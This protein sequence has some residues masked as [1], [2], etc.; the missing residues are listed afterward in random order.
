MRSGTLLTP[1]LA[2]AIIASCLFVAVALLLSPSAAAAAADATT[3]GPQ[4]GNGYAGTLAGS[5]TVGIVISGLFSGRGQDSVGAAIPNAHIR[6]AAP[7]AVGS[8]FALD[9][10]V[11]VATQHF[12]GVAG[13]GSGAAAAVNGTIRTYFHRVHKNILVR[14]VSVVRG[15]ADAA[16]PVTVPL[17]RVVD[18]NPNPALVEQL[19]PCSAAGCVYRTLL[20][21]T[22]ASGLIVVATAEP[23]EP[24]SIQLAAGATNATRVFPLAVVTSMPGDQH[25]APAS[26]AAAQAAAAAA[27]ANFAAES[28][29]QRYAEHAQAWAELWR[30]R[31][32][33]V[34]AAA[35][36]GSSDAALGA[37]IALVVRESQYQLLIALREGWHASTNPGGVVGCYGSS[38]FWDQET[39]MGPVL[40]LLQPGLARSMVAYRA[41]RAAGARENARH[42]IGVKVGAAFPWQSA[43]TGQSSCPWLQG[44]ITELHITGDVVAYWRQ[45]HNLG[46][47]NLT[48]AL[49]PLIKETADYWVARSTMGPG[50]YATCPGVSSWMCHVGGGGGGGARNSQ[51]RKTAAAATTTILEVTS[52]D[53]YH[54]CNSS[55]YTNVVARMNVDFAIA[56]A[57]ELGVPADPQWREFVDSVLVLYDAERDIHPEFDGYAGQ[58]IKQADVILLGAMLNY[59]YETPSTQRNDLDLYQNTT[60]PGGPAM[61]WA[62]TATGYFAVGDAVQGERFFLKGFQDY[63]FLPQNWPSSVPPNYLR[64]CEVA[65]GGGCQSF[66]TGAG[67]FLQSIPFGLLGLRIRN[68]RTILLMPSKMHLP[69]SADAVA[70]RGIHFFGARL[71]FELRRRRSAQP[72]V[73]IAV[74]LVS[75]PPAGGRIMASNFGELVVGGR[76]MTLV[77][78]NGAADEWIYYAD[79]P[80]RMK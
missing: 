44:T 16:A 12:A 62:A 6:F 63:V 34:P 3:V 48:R 59:E 33:F 64:W 51:H 71:S 47:A 45:L 31:I 70:A 32:D 15:A 46:Y 52:P 77:K 78:T 38:R 4:I 69:A 35:H 61:T 73:E 75:A 28:D 13:S 2:A 68:N 41:E 66:L 40:G 54:C 10:G 56:A 42:N 39:W 17:A 29:A 43:Y 22:N 9:H 80:R 1:V 5:S 11:S 25:P 53:E 8:L 24:G 60:D 58:K 74:A 18:A 57:A 21:E 67:G 49:F 55:V 7:T 30:N 37:H 23:G 65:G 19:S 79:G 27:L 50:G 20:A 36:N 72:T 76:A 14:E 26:A